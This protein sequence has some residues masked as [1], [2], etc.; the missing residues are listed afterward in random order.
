[1]QYETTVRLRIV[2]AD[3]H[4]KKIL[5]TRT[6]ESTS[7]YRHVRFQ[8]ERLQEEL[9]AALSTAIEKIFEDDKVASLIEEITRVRSESIIR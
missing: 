3:V 4:H 8:E 7:S 2:F 5:Y 6:L 9:N 1:M